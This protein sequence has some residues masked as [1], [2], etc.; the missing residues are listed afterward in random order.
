M[1]GQTKSYSYTTK[2]E[3]G[4]TTETEKVFTPY[5]ASQKD[6]KSILDLFLLISC[7]IFPIWSYYIMANHDEKY[8]TS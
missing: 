6:A 1:A 4:E 3:N 2:W 7:F 5:D 8:A